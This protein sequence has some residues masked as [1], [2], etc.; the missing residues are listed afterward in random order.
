MYLRPGG[1]LVLPDELKIYDTIVLRVPGDFLKIFFIGVK[2]RKIPDQTNKY[3][4]IHSFYW[5]IFNRPGEIVSY[6]SK[7]RSELVL[8]D[9][10]IIHGTICLWV[11]W[12]FLQKILYWCERRANPRLNKQIHSFYWITFNRPGEIISYV[13][14]AGR[15]ISSA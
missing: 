13:S 14:K 3:L 8:L 6:V 7:T 10:E 15:R 9:E 12:R 2:D 5:I 4:Q 1:E 11:P